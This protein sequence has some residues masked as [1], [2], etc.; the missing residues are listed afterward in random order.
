MQKT[1]YTPTGELLILQPDDKFSPEH[2]FL[3]PGTGLYRLCGGRESATSVISTAHKLRVAVMAFLNS[4]HPLDMLR[5]KSA[6]GSGGTIYK[7]HDMISYARAVRYV[8]RLELIRLKEQRKYF[9]WPLLVAASQFKALVA[10]VYALHLASRVRVSFSGL[11]QM[12]RNSFWQ[13]SNN[14]ASLRLPFVLLLIPVR[15]LLFKLLRVIY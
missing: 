12:G 1:L 3:P 2:H 14:V 9:W 6:Y 10:L 13:I 11:M 4:P 8:M 5:S 15:F 7:H